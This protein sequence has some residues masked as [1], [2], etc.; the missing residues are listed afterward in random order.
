MGKYKFGNELQEPALSGKGSHQ[1]C[2]QLLFED[3]VW[4]FVNNHQMDEMIGDC[5]NLRRQ[6]DMVHRGFDF[7]SK[8]LCIEMKVFIPHSNV[9]YGS[10]KKRFQQSMKQV[11]G[12]VT[13]SSGLDVGGKRII[14]FW[15][16]RKGISKEIKRIINKEIAELLNRATD[17]EVELWVAEMKLELSDGIELL[18]YKNITDDISQL[19]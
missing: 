15:V 1:I 11:I 13:D 4:F 14:L 7:E 16:G 5:K 19:K 17:M 10:L 3:A 2:N 6:A 18:S 9:E 8:E 12:Y